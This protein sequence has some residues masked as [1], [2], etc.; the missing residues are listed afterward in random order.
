MLITSS[1]RVA[2]SPAGRV[3]GGQ[4]PRAL[5]SGTKVGAR[6]SRLAGRPGHA[7]TP[8]SALRAGSPSPA[9]GRGTTC[10]EPVPAAVDPAGEAA[11][12]WACPRGSLAARKMALSHAASA[13]TGTTAM[14]ASCHADRAEFGFMG[15]HSL[16]VGEAVA[17]RYDPFD[18]P[19]L[20]QE[21]P[22]LLNGSGT[23]EGHD[24]VLD[25]DGEA[26]RAL[27]ELVPGHVLRD[28]L[29]DLVVGAAI[30]TQQGGPADDPGQMTVLTD[31][32]KSF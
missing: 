26:A 8:P 13:A 12:A 32:R 22:A 29:A 9:T 6:E 17:H 21:L 28:F 31:H 1:C 2:L 7:A 14:T 25:R 5:I 24:A 30:D 20:G 4:E 27:E 23:F 19:N 10:A 18:S 16:R 3:P 15:L 11:G